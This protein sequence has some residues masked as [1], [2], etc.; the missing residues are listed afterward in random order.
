MSVL[1][2][3]RVARRDA[4]CTRRI[5]AGRGDDPGESDPS[6]NRD[7]RSARRR[8]RRLRVL[9]RDQRAGVG[10]VASGTGAL[11]EDV[12]TLVT[13][14]PLLRMIEAGVWTLAFAPA[15]IFLVVSRRPRPVRLECR[16]RRR[17]VAVSRPDR[18]RGDGGHAHRHARRDRCDRVRRTRAP[19]RIDRTG[20][21]DR[22]PSRS[23]S[24]SRCR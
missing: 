6:A 18:R 4:V 24:R 10:V 17:G 14:M 7:G 20:G 2:R 8:C 16:S 11:L 1:R 5:D 19:R 9:P 22:R 23:S 12:L 21:S 13:G 3:T 15:P